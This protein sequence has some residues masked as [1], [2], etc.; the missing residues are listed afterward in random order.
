MGR[1]GGSCRRG[2][3]VDESRKETAD[4]VAKYQNDYV[5]R[6]C[7][8]LL[9][10][11]LRLPRVLFVVLR[12]S[13]PFLSLLAVLCLCCCIVLFCLSHIRGWQDTSFYLLIYLLR[14]ICFIILFASLSLSLFS[15]IALSTL[16]TALQCTW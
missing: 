9:F 6:T 5:G 1:G 16:L 4:S 7:L 13:C 11:L 2:T 8:S 15:V 3:A 14:S 10:V 12:F